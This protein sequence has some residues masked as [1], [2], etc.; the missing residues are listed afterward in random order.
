[1]QP[2]EVAATALLGHAIEKLSELFQRF[3]DREQLGQR[4]GAS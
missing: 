2:T 3:D 4:H 1:V